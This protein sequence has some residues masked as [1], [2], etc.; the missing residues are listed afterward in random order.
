M[1]LTPLRNLTPLPPSPNTERGERGGYYG[2][3]L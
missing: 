1:N 3:G 2:V